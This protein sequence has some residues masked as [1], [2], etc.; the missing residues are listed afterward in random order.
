LKAINSRLQNRLL[1]AAAVLILV[2][3]S[4]SDNNGPRPVVEPEPVP[5]PA[6]LL[7]ESHSIAS[8]AEPAHTP[9]SPGVVVTNPKMLIQ[10]GGGD[11]SLNNALYTRYYMSDQAEMQP[12]AILVMVPG[13]NGASANYPILAENL[14]PRIR[15][16]YAMVVEVWAVS[17]RSLALQDRVGLELAESE[18]DIAIALDFG[19]GEELGL[20]LD[21]ALEEGPNRRLITYNHSDDTAFFAN[22][23]Q[24]VHSRDIDAI[25]AVA[26]DTAR[27]NNVFLGGQ[28]FGT[29]YVA[30][31]AATD[32]NFTGG[33]PDPGYAKLRGLVLLEGGGSSLSDQPPSEKV[34]DEIEARFDGGL[35]GAIRDQAPRCIDGV[36]ACRKATEITDC[37]A[38][39]NTSCTAPV[40]AFPAGLLTTELFYLGEMVAMDGDWSGDSGLSIAQQ[41]Q[42]GIPGNNAIEQVPELFAVKL[43]IGD[44]PGTSTS[45]FGQFFDDDGAAAV[46]LPNLSAAVGFVGPVVD[47]VTT[48]LGTGENIPDTAYADNGPAPTEPAQ[49]HIWGLEE[50]ATD[51]EGRW[52]AT[53]YKGE[54]SYFEWYYPSSGQN[55]TSGLELDTSA[56]SLPPPAGRGRSDIENRTQAQA[57]DIPVI[58]FG[59]SNGLTPVPGMFLPFADALAPCVTASCDGLTPRVVDRT[60]PSEA[61]PTF[62]EVAGGFEVYISEGY[63]HF[64]VLTADDDETNNVIGPLVQFLQRNSP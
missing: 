54:A 36:T 3:C 53:L 1:S 6:V 13:F 12:D 57:I 32:F 29:G 19:F 30:A 26:Q 22:W 7:A 55:V 50:E 64:D 48:W 24:L 63:S 35:Y 52:L 11:F 46:L 9:G 25:V 21:P 33:E 56:L 37:A 43:L 61:F 5:E 39:S 18:Q 60:Q 28:S 34:L 27:N 17:R 20:P 44:T 38:F 4:D 31:Y 62:G 42:L 10:F 40:P 41:D 23:T 8:S 16:E 59:A 58:A 2:A 15:D 47:D 51:I 49:G 45:L 14:L